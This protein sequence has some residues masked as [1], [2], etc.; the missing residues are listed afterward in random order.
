MLLRNSFC[1]TEFT[2]ILNGE[3]VKPKHAGKRGI[4]PPL[5][6]RHGRIAIITKSN[7]VEFRVEYLLNIR[8]ESYSPTNLL[9][10]NVHLFMVM[11][12]MMMIMVMISGCKSYK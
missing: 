1:T 3:T 5:A 11:M 10:D 12:T 6:W 4:I 9:G 2:A 8:L 7:S